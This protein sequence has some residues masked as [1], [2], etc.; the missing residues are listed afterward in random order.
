MK[1][2]LILLVVLFTLFT[3]GITAQASTDTDPGIKPG[4]FLY[5]FDI[6]LEKVDLF[7]T[8]DSE[9]KA[10]KAL[11]YADERLAE[12]KESANENKPK[13]V[14]KAM[15]G[16]KKE[17]SLATEKS[18]E[19]KDEKKS[20]E[21]LKTVSENTA[22]DQE[23]LKGILEK[24]SGEAKEAILKAID[25]SKRGQEEAIK[26]VGELQKEVV[27]LKQKVAKLEAKNKNNENNKT[28]ELKIKE[29]KQ[30]Q[31]IEKARLEAET[32]K[33]KAESIRIEKEKQA[34]QAELD[35][36][37]AQNKLTKNKEEVKDTGIY[38][39]GKN[40]AQCPSGYSFSC[41][42]TGNATCIENV[43]NSDTFCNGK[44]WAP[45]ISGVFYCPASGDPVCRTESK[46]N[47]EKV[48]TGNDPVIT[49]LEK[50][51]AVRIEKNNS[52]LKKM[53][54][55]LAKYNP[56]I[57]NKQKELD[58]LNKEMDANEKKCGGFCIT[59]EGA[60]ISRSLSAEMISVSSDINSLTG[61]ER[62]ELS[63]EIPGFP[64]FSS[65]LNTY[66]PSLFK[67]SERFVR[68]NTVNGSTLLRITPDNLGGYYVNDSTNGRSYKIS[69]SD[70]GDYYVESY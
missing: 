32:A 10:R 13:A 16:Y 48:I 58:R 33:A 37:K 44:N 30:D 9:D 38:C 49:A 39:N 41:P 18:K 70:Y 22:K 4:S 5:I 31:E 20:E 21:L 23:V 51:L 63:N 14:E 17:I 25:I 60:S 28:E 29:K 42:S 11:R 34:L 35:K 54:D 1:K 67:D 12:A 66:K 69:P 55:I 27:G 62:L 45:C 61:K 8:F 50:E 53:D 47:N 15:E 59:G 40:W 43:Q 3:G 26:Q 19:I 68:I 7:F 52:Y 6:T 64:A 56:L 2:Y 46:Q 36:V 57:E 24:V 65:D